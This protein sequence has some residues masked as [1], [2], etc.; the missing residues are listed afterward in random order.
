MSK[1]A[2]EIARNNAEAEVAPLTELAT[3]L[4][5]IKTEGGPAALKAY[6]RNMR[7]P[8]LSRTRRIVEVSGGSQ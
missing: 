1:R 7:V 5:K 6:L 8:L 2:V 3:T 4:T